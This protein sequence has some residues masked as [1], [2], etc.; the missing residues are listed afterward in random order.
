MRGAFRPHQ[1]PHTKQ[2]R[3]AP[4]CSQNPAKL[5]TQLGI[6]FPLPT[7][8][9]PHHYAHSSPA[10]LPPQQAFPG[11]RP[12][13]RTPQKARHL[14]EMAFPNGL[15]YRSARFFALMPPSD[16]CPKKPPNTPFSGL[17]RAEDAKKPTFPFFSPFSRPRTRTPPILLVVTAF[18]AEISVSGVISHRCP[19]SIA[20]TVFILRHVQ[21]NT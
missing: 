2:N 8:A 15:N 16:S 1:S 14:H 13:L 3:R 7:H 12:H 9:R 17:V 18:G 4:T 21:E 19:H 5:P 10:K 11:A 6:S 20:R